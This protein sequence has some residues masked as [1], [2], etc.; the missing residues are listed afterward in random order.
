VARHHTLDVR[1]LDPPEPVERALAAIA[2]FEPGDTLR[3]LIDYEPLPLYRILD[4][5]GFAHV[6]RPG[7]RSLYEIEIR[8]QE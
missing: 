1:G 3:L 4:H 5:N 7:T 2:D 8:A 6:A